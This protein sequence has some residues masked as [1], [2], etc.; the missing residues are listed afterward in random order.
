M[1]AKNVETC[2]KAHARG[3]LETIFAKVWPLRRRPCRAVLDGLQNE[4]W[5]L[6]I[7]PAH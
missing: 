1:R 6:L 3:G 2:S 7:S 5:R 4:R